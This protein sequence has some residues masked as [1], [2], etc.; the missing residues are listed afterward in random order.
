[1]TELERVLRDVA[2]QEALIA[3]ALAA[4]DTIARAPLDVTGQQRTRAWAIGQA[5]R[6]VVAVD[7][8]LRNERLR[9]EYPIV[10]RAGVAGL[11][12]EFARLL[13]EKPPA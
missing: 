1:V 13:E 11:L 10:V 4:S 6:L 3:K 7:T 8:L 12:K 5:L 2:Q 9:D